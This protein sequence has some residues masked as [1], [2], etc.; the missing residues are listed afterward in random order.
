MLITKK[1]KLLQVVGREGVLSFEFYLD[2]LDPQLVQIDNR[3]YYILC[4]L[5]NQA[6]IHH[7]RIFSPLQTLIDVLRFT[8]S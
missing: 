4:I 1:K 7:N 8:L 2:K 6:V 3:F 5:F